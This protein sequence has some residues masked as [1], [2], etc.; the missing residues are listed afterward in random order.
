MTMLRS[1]DWRLVFLIV[2]ALVVRLYRVTNPIAD[3]HAFRQVDTASVTREYV[4]HGIDILRPRYQD[5]SNIQ[6]G[7]DNPHGY[8]MVEFPIVNAVIAFF[9]KVFP[10]FDLGIISRL[11]SIAASLGIAELFLYSMLHNLY[12]TEGSS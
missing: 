2:M 1:L 8:R 12:L 3:W 11:F 6:S 4:K 10:F 5:L 7:F 9:L